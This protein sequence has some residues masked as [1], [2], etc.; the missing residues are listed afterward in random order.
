MKNI[1]QGNS[2]GIIIIK[3]RK[4]ITKHQKSTC[5]WEEHKSST[6]RVYYY[7]VITDHSQSKKPSRK[8]LSASSSYANKSINKNHIHSKRI[9][10]TPLLESVFTSFHR[11]R[12][13]KIQSNQDI[14][15]FIIR[16]SLRSSSSTINAILELEHSPSV[17]S[18][19][20][21]HYSSSLLSAMTISNSNDTKRYHSGE[22]IQFSPTKIERQA[23]H[24]S[25]KQIQIIT[26]Q[27]TSI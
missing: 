26:C 22:S 20:Q 9:L 3:K 12:T 17:I 23:L 16:S 24:S 19:N 11:K 21:H 6:D 18:L 7:N 2:F 15:H 4:R 14:S 25:N 27:L 8:Q 5:W 10:T 1:E 13:V